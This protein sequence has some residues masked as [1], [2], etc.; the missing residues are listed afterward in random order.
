MTP[1]VEIQIAGPRAD[2]I[3]ARPDVL[4]ALDW[5]TF[6]AFAD[7]VAEVEGNENVRV[8]VV[9]GRGRS[10]SSGI[11]TSAFG[12]FAGDVRGMIARAQKAYRRLA[13]LPLPT[14]AAVRGH[15]LGA[16]FQ[17]ALACD[18]CIVTN[19]AT[20][21]L[22]EARFGIIPDLGGTQRLA[23][24]VGPAQAKRMI[25]L[26][27]KIDGK[28]AAALGIAQAAVEDD[29]LDTAVDALA[30]ALAAAP[31]LAVAAAKRLVDA[32]SSRSITASMDA[33][34]LEQERLLASA[35][36]AEGVSAFLQRRQPAWRRA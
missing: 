31:P 29:D 9:G 26:A 16:G 24:L 22:L 14:I 21:G 30:D 28:R 4:N 5:R 25:W 10:F 20:L 18:L 33:E 8:V 3:L 27:E 36:F 11:D 34:A 7:A 23:D 35:D 15:A 13:S 12:D 32:A 19:G 1:P 17:I 6:D 2:I